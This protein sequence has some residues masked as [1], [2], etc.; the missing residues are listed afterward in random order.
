ML[1]YS[2]RIVDDLS[3]TMNPSQATIVYYYCDYTDQRTLQTDRIL[4]TILKQLL[5]DDEI[6]KENVPQILQAYRNGQRIPGS[7]E[8]SDIVC[9][10]IYKHPVAYFVF[11][12]LDECEKQPRQDILNLLNQ[13][14]TFEKVSVRALVTCRDEDQLLRSLLSYPRIQLTAIA[15]GGDIELFVKGSVRSRIDSGQLTIKDP[16]LEHQIVQELVDKAH[17]M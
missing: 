3:T 12:G 2:S 16:D 14:A 5:P 13:L 15:L 4:G 9:S 7:H 17:G 10:L 1:D 11:D 8:L 6:P